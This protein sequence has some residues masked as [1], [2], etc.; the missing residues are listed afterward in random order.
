VEEKVV[1]LQARKR[2]LAGR[3]VRSEEEALA[4]LT[5]EDLRRVLFED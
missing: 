3:I 4:A 5:A 1:E 2:D